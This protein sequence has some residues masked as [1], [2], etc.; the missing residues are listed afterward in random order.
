MATFQEELGN[1]F[2]KAAAA[3]PDRY[4]VD[5]QNYVLAVKNG[6]ESGPTN[7]DPTL[8]SPDNGKGRG[9]AAGPAQMLEGTYNGAA[10]KLA[11]LGVKLS[12][13]S[14]NNPED[15]QLAYL[16]YAREARLAHPDDLE[17][18]FAYW[19]GGPGGAAADKA[20]WASK[21]DNLGTSIARYV[22]TVL[23]VYNGTATPA[24]S[25]ASVGAKQ[26]DT[27]AQLGQFQDT[28][29]KLQDVIRKGATAGAD[30]L[31]IAADGATRLATDAQGI[32]AKL[33][34]GGDA[35][36]VGQ[37]A[38]NIERNAREQEAAG[39]VMDVF[40]TGFLAPVIRGFAPN[41]IKTNQDLINT[42]SESNSKLLA[43]L[44]NT[45]ATAQ[46]VLKAR[47][48]GVD[49]SDELRAKA[50]TTELQGEA[51]ALEVAA[52]SQKTIIN[53]TQQNT[54]FNA[55]I[56]QQ[57]R[58]FNAQREDA[59]ARDTRENQ[60]IAIAQAKADKAQLF[61]GFA[62]GR[63]ISEEDFNN[64][65]GSLGKLGLDGTKLTPFAVK[66]FVNSKGNEDIG[67]L[68][69][70]ANPT[71]NPGQIKRLREQFGVVDPQVTKGQELL[72]KDKFGDNLFEK[73][74]GTDPKL[75]TAERMAKQIGA[76]KEDRAAF[77]VVKDEAITRVAE[78]AQ[79]LDSNALPKDKNPYAAKNATILGQSDQ[80]ALPYLAPARN[81]E[82]GQRLQA[83]QKAVLVAEPTAAKSI[84]DYTIVGEA[85]KMLKEGKPIPAVASQLSDYFKA[86]AQYNNDIHRF[87]ANGYPEQ[88]RYVL[89]PD[90][91]N[92]LFGSKGIAPQKTSTATQYNLLDTGEAISL[93]TSLTRK[94]NGK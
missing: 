91:T 12:P 5:D 14:S 75:A 76:K 65:R 55:Q 32:L 48:L 42:A 47:S 88:T 68:I 74:K 9:K 51:K 4:S 19:I 66:Q 70:Q 52:N 15:Q 21:K 94:L 33:G 59:N 79:N 24:G 77:E 17:R 49:N 26:L 53:E 54:R 3:F 81:S 8:R 92:P 63:S 1:T 22:A 89:Q 10:A 78:Q 16:E 60:R 35:P 34:L 30:E 72:E 46:Q 58:V 84:E 93:L 86:A 38:K 43:E 67:N 87:G 13:W 69:L 83:I 73:A 18:R 23:P 29:S 44:N 28:I 2:A 80:S 6:I 45:A 64:I 40:G 7:N 27:T 31:R 85:L 82:L 39:Q 62:N 11:T 56:A 50:R 20:S 90:V 41:L 25:A 71:P 37:I 36:R 57:D 61:S